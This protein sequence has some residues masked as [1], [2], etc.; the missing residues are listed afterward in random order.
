[1]FGSSVLWR[2]SLESD[3][4]GDSSIVS[5]DV[6]SSAMQRDGPSS[7]SM[8]LI[9]G[10][11]LITDSKISSKLLLFVGEVTFDSSCGLFGS[12]PSSRFVNFLIELVLMSKTRGSPLARPVGAGVCKAPW[13]WAIF[14]RPG[15]VPSASELTFRPLILAFWPTPVLWAASGDP[16]AAVGLVKNRHHFRSQGRRDMNH[17]TF[18]RRTPSLS[19]S[20][21]GPVRG[22]F[23]HLEEATE[24]NVETGAPPNGPLFS[25]LVTGFGT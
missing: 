18:W 13:S 20:V 25:W 10:N 9:F 1:M 5:V 11:S 24:P 4:S 6:S 3:D 8:R 2:N 23:P 12:V 16:L 7:P 21:T 17:R 19:S 22:S 15:P 14:C